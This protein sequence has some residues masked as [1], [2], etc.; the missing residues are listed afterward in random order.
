VNAT[1]EQAVTRRKNDRRI[2]KGRPAAGREYSWLSDL[3]HLGARDWVGGPNC[4]VAVSRPWRIIR[5]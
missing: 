4:G 2:M 1:A 3:L 5:L